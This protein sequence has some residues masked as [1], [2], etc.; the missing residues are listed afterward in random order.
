VNQRKYT[1]DEIDQLRLKI[2]SRLFPNEIEIE[3]MYKNETYE[4]EM[5]R[6]AALVEEQLRTAMIAGVDP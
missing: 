4:R 5:A 2:R 6:K 1:L 3:W